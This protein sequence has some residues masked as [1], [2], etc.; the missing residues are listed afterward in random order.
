VGDY[1]KS[2]DAAEA[3]LQLG[4]SQEFSGQEEQAAKW[5]AQ[6]VKD[7]PQSPAAQKAA[8]AQ[9]RLESVGKVLALSG[10]SP[11][12]GV[13]DIAKLRGKPVLVHYWATWSEPAKSDIATIKELVRKYG[14][15]FGAVGV[16]LDLNAKDATAFINEAKMSWPQIWEQG[17]LDSRP[18]NQLGIL[19]VPTTML[20]DGQGRVVHRAVPSN[21]LEVELRKLLK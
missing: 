5:Y 8:G 3:M 4:I 11:A 10:Q 18:A 13:V 1:P 7:F 6:I 9:M 2:P 17:G 15:N 12:G 14:A 20:I 19:T 16:N 21:E